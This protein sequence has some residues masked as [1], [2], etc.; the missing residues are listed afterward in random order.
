MDWFL[1]D[2]GLRY[3]RVKGNPAMWKTVG[4]HNYFL[5]VFLYANITGLFHKHIDQLILP[6]I[7]GWLNPFWEVFV[8]FMGFL[9]GHYLPLVQLS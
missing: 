7:I 1:Y 2:N 3:E 9:F 8:T 5:S 6:Q 4:W